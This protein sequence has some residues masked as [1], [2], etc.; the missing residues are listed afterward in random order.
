MSEF[1]TAGAASTVGE[2]IARAFVGRGLRMSLLGRGT[3]T[4]DR[5]GGDPKVTGGEALAMPTDVADADRVERAAALLV[6]A[7]IAAVQSL[8][9]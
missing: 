7:G 6:A 9:Q 2:A 3:D 4:V 8:R 5:P 1:V